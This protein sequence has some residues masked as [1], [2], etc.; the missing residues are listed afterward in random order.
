[1]VVVGGMVLVLALG[2]FLPMWELI[3]KV[4]G[5]GGGWGSLR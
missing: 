5:G 3:A 2:V 4:G 1:V